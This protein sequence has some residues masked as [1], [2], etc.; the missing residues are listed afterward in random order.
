MIIRRSPSQI[1]SYTVTSPERI[2]CTT[3]IITCLLVTILALVQGQA[4]HPFA[5]ILSRVV[6]RINDQTNKS[7]Q[8]HLV[9]GS[10]VLRT[11]PGVNSAVYS[12]NKQSLHRILKMTASSSSDQLSISSNRS[13]SPHDL[14]F[15]SVA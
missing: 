6:Q 14:P 15:W 5:A 7:D 12:R 1:I 13:F 8:D 4:L 10:E 9:K 2:A 11:M 3:C